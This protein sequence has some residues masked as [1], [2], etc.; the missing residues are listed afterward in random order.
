M[1]KQ[2]GA[3]MNRLSI[4]GNRGAFTVTKEVTNIILRDIPRDLIK[5]KK[6]MVSDSVHS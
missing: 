5:K 3:Y 1:E 4:N 2:L 6:S